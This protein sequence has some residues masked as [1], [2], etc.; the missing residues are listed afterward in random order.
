MRMISRQESDDWLKAKFSKGFSW[1]AVKAAYPHYVTYL[2]PTDTGARTCI[3]RMLSGYIDATEPGLLLVKEW[4]VWP[5]SENMALFD[6]YRKSL[7]ES[8]CIHEAP[9]HL[10]D[11]SDLTSVECLL[12]LALYFLWN[13]LLVDGAGSMVAFTSHDE[14]FSVY[15]RDQSGFEEIKLWLDKMDLTLTSTQP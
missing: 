3:A 8:R 11:G 1:E 5:S 13:T 15:M 12:D 10:F 4:G 14:W 7:G 6:G 2:L 9:G